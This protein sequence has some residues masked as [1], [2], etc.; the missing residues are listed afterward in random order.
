[1]SFQTNAQKIVLL[2]INVVRLFTDPLADRLIGIIVKRHAVTSAEPTFKARVLDAFGRFTTSANKKSGSPIQQYTEH[3]QKSV[4]PY[5]DSSRLLIA[6]FI[7]DSLKAIKDQWY[8]MAVGDSNFDRTLC[9]AL[10]YCVILAGAA[11]Y[12]RHTQN[13]QA[14]EAGAAV[15]EIVKQHFTLVK[16]SL[17]SR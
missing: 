12:L 10:G 4:L 1:M 14:R 16:V 8:A 15:R 5:I 11:A 17:L 7:A 9:I 13:T 3:L 6:K 2:P